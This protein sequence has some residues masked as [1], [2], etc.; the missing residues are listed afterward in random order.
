MNELALAIAFASNL[1]S[2]YGG[3]LSKEQ[4][5]KAVR[6]GLGYEPQQRKLLVD[7][8][9]HLAV[10]KGS[11]TVDGL[12]YGLEVEHHAHLAAAYENMRVLIG[13]LDLRSAMSLPLPF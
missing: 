9:L 6:L 11:E 5:S 12:L 8:L 2:L 13:S 7:V 3:H 4:L 10:A 1:T